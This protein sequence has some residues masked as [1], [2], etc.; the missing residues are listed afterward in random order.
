MSTEPTNRAFEYVKASEIWPNVEDFEDKGQRPGILR[1]YNFE[2][3][4]PDG[5][6]YWLSCTHIDKEPKTYAE[7][8]FF[9]R[10]LAELDVEPTGRVCFRGYGYEEYD[11]DEQD[12]YI[13][14]VDL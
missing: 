12:V 5:S 13:Q 11:P 8:D 1:G 7:S 6:T 3:K 10:H 2:V 4:R 9:L 14:H